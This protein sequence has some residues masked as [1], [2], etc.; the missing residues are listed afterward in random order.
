MKSR[1]RWYACTACSA[2][3]RNQKFRK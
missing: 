1:L 3:G 2:S